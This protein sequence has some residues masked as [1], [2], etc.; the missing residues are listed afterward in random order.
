MYSKELNKVIGR[1]KT[2][3]DGKITI[4]NIR[5]GEYSLI[6]EKTN[7]WYNLAK[8]KNL[9]VKWNDTTVVTV[10][11]ELKKSR[12][13]VIKE[14]K[15]DNK[16]KLKNVKFQVLDK[17]NN[18]LETI[19]TDENGEAVTSKYA[20]K[21]YNELYLKE[22]KTNEKYVL[23]DK[24]YKV[25]LKENQTVNVVIQ[26]KKIKGQIKIIKT[27]KKNNKITN[28][29]AGDP[30]EGVKF[31]I[32][33][34]NKNLIEIVTTDK[35]GEAITGMLDKG[36]KYVKELEAAK[37]YVLDEKEYSIEIKSD[38][39]I[40]SLNLENIPENPEVSIE[41]TGSSKVKQGQEILYNFNVKNVGNV[42]LDNFTWID[43]L[44]KENVKLSNITFPT[45]FTL[46]V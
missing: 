30:I 32:Y 36:K 31:G 14:D 5:T 2:D 45:F 21:D 17:N 25:S 27:T 16:I 29:N 33:D 38:G 20:L 18:I 43:Y 3:K 37:F 41:K 19:I 6:E 40:S 42:M 39:Q 35:K 26:N 28:Q 13:K 4:N 8:D 24:I 9:K 15:E 10:E 11:N 44:P 12:I 1:Y 46:K 22:I 7:K 23:D 34:E